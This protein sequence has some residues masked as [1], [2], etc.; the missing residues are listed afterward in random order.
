DDDGGADIGSIISQLLG[1]INTDGSDG[2]NADQGVTNP[3]RHTDGVGDANGDSGEV[4]TTGN[5]ERPDGANPLPYTGGGGG[6]GDGDESGEVQDTGN[7]YRQGDANPVP[8]TGGGGGDSDDSGEVQ[9][10]GNTYRAGRANTLPYT[11]GGGGDGD[12]DDSGEVQDT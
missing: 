12:G 11:G 1:G 3:E 10:T 7:I 5:I 8:Y 2:N 6:D 9:A 4:K